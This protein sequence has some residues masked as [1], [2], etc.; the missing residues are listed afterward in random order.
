MRA[1]VVF[2]MILLGAGNAL[3]SSERKAI[4]R[5]VVA[6]ARNMGVAPALALAV[7][8]AESYFDPTV[9]SHKGARGVMQIMPQTAW[10]EYGIAPEQLWQPR[11]NIRLGLHFLQRLL[12][13]Y[14]GRVDLALSYYNGGSAVGDLP[15]ARIIPATY[16]YVRKVVKLRLN[17]SRRISMGSYDE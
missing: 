17:Y 10:E 5:L 1:A 2:L 14:R 7:A 15:R 4:Q 9:V 11:I 13:R 16:A 8:H 6:E 12:G 3:A